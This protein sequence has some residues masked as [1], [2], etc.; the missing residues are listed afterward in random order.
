MSCAGNS[1]LGEIDIKQGIFQG[2]PLSPLVFVLALIPLSLILRK[3]KATAKTAGF[4]LI[5]R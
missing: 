5:L 3:A 2:D 4:G 1:E